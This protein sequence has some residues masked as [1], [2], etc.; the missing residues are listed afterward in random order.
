[1]LQEIDSS[2]SFFPE[3]RIVYEITWENMVRATQAVA[4][5]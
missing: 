5:K 1:M 3:N 4:Y 2:W